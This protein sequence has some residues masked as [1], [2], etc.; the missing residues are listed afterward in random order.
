MV[1]MFIKQLIDLA[2][3][4]DI[5]HGDITTEYLI[6]KEING[7]GEIIAKEDIVFCGADICELVFTRLDPKCRFEH[8]FQEGDT[9]HS[10]QTLS[11][12]YA[13]AQ[14]LLKGERTALNFLQRLCGIATHVRS[15]VQA[16]K[17][18]PIRLVDTRKTTPGWRFLE[19]R[20]VRAGGAKNHRMALYDGVM[21]K[22][23]HIVLCGSIEN[24]VTTLRSVVSPLVKIEV[25]VSTMEQVSDAVN[26]GADVIM[27][28]NMSLEQMKEAVAF[29]NG[30]A[31]I[32]VS[33]RLTKSNIESLSQLKIDMISMG[34]LTHQATSVDLSMRI[35]PFQ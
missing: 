27:L 15:Y 28:D 16:M 2:L 33:G 9:V 18:I 5:G 11:V 32:E 20:A 6:P 31:W 17:N 30:R 24:A 22:D 14:A 4:E 19:K 26:S 25:E 34:A 10:G 7:I 35:A 1:N 8:C 3:N 23:N 21:I 29:I 13:S 12:I